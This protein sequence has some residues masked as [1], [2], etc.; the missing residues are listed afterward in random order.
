MV[1]ISL[2]CICKIYIYFFCRKESL[3]V[4]SDKLVMKDISEAP[5]FIRKELKRFGFNWASYKV[6]D[7]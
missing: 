4:L 2:L 5:E 6:L 7:L 3:F 1:N